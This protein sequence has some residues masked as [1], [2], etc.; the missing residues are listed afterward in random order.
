MYDTMQRLCGSSQEQ[1]RVT[2]SYL[3]HLTRWEAGQPSG[4]MLYIDRRSLHTPRD[5]SFLLTHT[6]YQIADWLKFCITVCRFFGLRS[7]VHYYMLPARGE[8]AE[9]SKQAKWG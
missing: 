9:H 1:Y 7:A 3:S 6:T 2:D 5:C 8:K 4:T